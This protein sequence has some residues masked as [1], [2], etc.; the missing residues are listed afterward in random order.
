MFSDRPSPVFQNDASFHSSE[1]QSVLGEK[2]L[3][4]QSSGSRTDNNQAMGDNFTEEG[5]QVVM[6]SF[7][8]TWLGH[9]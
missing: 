5:D 1:A 4:D 9:R 6:V 3:A 7:L 2:I 8:P